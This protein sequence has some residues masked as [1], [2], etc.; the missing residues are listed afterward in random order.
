MCE[1]GNLGGSGI[2]NVPVVS[3]ALPAF[4]NQNS[5]N[6]KQPSSKIVNS[7]GKDPQLTITVG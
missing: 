2:G 5:E 1:G 4:K 7:S 3:R 6:Q